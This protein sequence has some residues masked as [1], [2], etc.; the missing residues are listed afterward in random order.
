MGRLMRTSDALRQKR[1]R[2]RRRKRLVPVQVLV[3]QQ[4]IDFLVTTYELTP[5]DKASI[6]RAVEAF[7][8]DTVLEDDAR[9]L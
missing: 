6:G 5:G 8:S 7:L 3:R 4:E 9:G 2:D 1:C